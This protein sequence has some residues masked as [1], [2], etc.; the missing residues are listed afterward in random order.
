MLHPPHPYCFR[1]AII[2]VAFHPGHSL[3]TTKIPPHQTLTL[4]MSK[5]PSPIPGSSLRQRRWPAFQAVFPALRPSAATKRHHWSPFLSSSS[6]SLSRASFLQRPSLTLTR[7]SFDN[8]SRPFPAQRIYAVSSTD[9]DQEQRRTNQ[10]TPTLIP[11]SDQTHNS[12]TTQELQPDCRYA[13][14]DDGNTAR[15]FSNLVKAPD[16]TLRRQ[17]PSELAC[18]ALVAVR[19]CFGHH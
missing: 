8:T 13:N 17:P 16:G 5:S 19:F 6:S 3:S 15:M 10:T 11:L 9:T 4:E 18:T 2:L 7:P 14:D 12:N 1:L